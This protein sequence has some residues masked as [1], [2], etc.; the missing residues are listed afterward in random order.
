MFALSCV[1]VNMI[2]FTENYLE[3]VLTI[4]ECYKLNLLQTKTNLDTFRDSL[5]KIVQNK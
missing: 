2:E 5:K 3:T 4:S 1:D